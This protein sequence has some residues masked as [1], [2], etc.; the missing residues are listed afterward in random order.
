[1]W[2]ATRS[3]NQRSCVITTAQ[4][5]N[6]SSASSSARSVST[7]RSFVG[8]SSSRTL[9]PERR[10]F[11]RWTRFRISFQT[12]LIGPSSSPCATQLLPRSRRGFRRPRRQRRLLGEDVRRRLACPVGAVGAVLRAVLV[13]RLSRGQRLEVLEDGVG[14]LEP[15][16]VTVRQE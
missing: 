6:S 15:L 4:P 12:Y 2:V 8:S 14:S 10:S 3:R 5:A 9:P 13:F 7:S 11:A 16:A 1:M